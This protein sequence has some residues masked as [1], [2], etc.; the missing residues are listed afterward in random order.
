[1]KVQF[2]FQS[3]TVIINNR[4]YPLSLIQEIVLEFYPKTIAKY[5][6][7]AIRVNGRNQFQYDWEG[8][9]K[10]GDLSPW[11]LRYNDF[12]FNDIRPVAG[13]SPDQYS[14]EAGLSLIY[15]AIKKQFVIAK[16]ESVNEG[17]VTIGLTPL[18]VA[19]D[20]TLSKYAALRIFCGLTRMH[21][22]DE[23]DAVES[24]GLTNR[25]EFDKYYKD[26]TSYLKDHNKALAAGKSKQKLSRFYNKVRLVL[27]YIETSVETSTFVSISD[28]GR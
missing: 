27:K 19:T 17:G 2:E 23:Q 16:E 10:S 13:F 15:R 3:D 14:S 7:K 21:G 4:R 25:D 26:F 22:F 9:F 18:Q 12:C 11:V 1:M 8:F 20:E 6:V 28:F 24:I 5:F